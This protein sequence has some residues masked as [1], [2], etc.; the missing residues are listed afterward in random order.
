MLDCYKWDGHKYKQEIMKLLLT[1]RGELG[2]WRG[3][4]VK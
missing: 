4:E 2:G 1:T 3:G